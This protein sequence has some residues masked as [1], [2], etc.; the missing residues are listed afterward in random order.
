M[1]W[2]GKL[3]L[4]EWHIIGMAVC[5]A[6]ILHI[7]ATLTVPSL[8]MSSAYSRLAALLPANTAYVLAPLSP[9]SQPLPFMV[10]EFRYA[11]CRIDAAESPIA[12]KT[13]LPGR[14]WIVTLYGPDGTSLFTE[15][16]QEGRTIEV[17]AQ[18]SSSQ[19]RFMGLTPE[20]L[21]K[22]RAA[23]TFISLSAREGIVVF[24]GPEP[25][26]AHRA[27][28]EAQLERLTCGPAFAARQ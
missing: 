20:A 14:G 2:I 6:G 3:K 24:Q 15:A 28:V 23:E 9:S 12:F 1:K 10:P 26:L 7:L 11:L 5:A 21:G 4:P 19:G 17:A 16:G 8:A 18:V 27:A 25:G 13:V 22:Q